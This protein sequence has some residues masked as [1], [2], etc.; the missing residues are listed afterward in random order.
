MRL[1]L[2][3]NLNKVF[4]IL[5][6]ILGTSSAL[7]AT[8]NRAGEITVEQIGPLTVRMTITTYT[9]ASSIE[10]DRDSLIVDW[11]DGKTEF[12]G[13]VNGNGN[14]VSI[15]N[16]TK[17]NQYIAEH[18]YPGR[19]TYTIGMADPNR[20]GGILNVNFPNSVTIQ[21]YLEIQY[22]FLNQQFQ[23]PNNTP[24][25]L[26]PPIDRGCVGQLFTHNPNAY[27]VDGDS[28]AYELIIPQ[29]GPDQVVPNY[30]YPNQ[31]SPG[32]NNNITF[33][34]LTGDFRWENPQRAGE[35]NIAMRINEYRNGQMI[36]STIR[37]LQIEIADCDNRP[38]TVEA[39]EE[40]CVIAGE[41]LNIPL[42]I[43]DPDF[44]D[45]VQITP[46][47]GPFVQD[48]SQAVL[49]GPSEFNDVP[50]DANIQWNTICDHVAPQP[51]TA[52]IRAVDSL[53]NG[54]LTTLKT[55]NIEV[56][57]PAPRDLEAIS[58]T[59][60]ITVS[61][62]SPYACEETNTDYFRGFDVW[63]KINSNPFEPEECETG[64]EGR[65]YTQIAFSVNEM[66][67]GRYTFV[68][69]DVEKGKTYCYR[70]TGV[71]A[72]LSP[73]G[74]PFNFV[75]SIPSEE[76]CQ[77]LK[78]DVPF[79]LN[80]DI[81]NTD[82]SQGEIFVRWIRPNPIDL[83]TIVNPGPYSYQLERSIELNTNNF[84]PIADAFFTYE[85]FSDPID[86]TYLD[87]G[88]NTVDNAYT[89]R[90]AFYTRGN[91]STPYEYSPIATSIRLNVQATDR[92]VNLNWE[93]FVPWENY[94]YA[95]FKFNE[96]SSTFD[97]IAV[98]EDNFY[99]D[100]EVKNEKEYCYV[101]KGYGQYGISELPFPLINFS[102]EICAVP[103]DTVPPCPPIITI[104]NPCTE[105][106]EL[107]TEFTNIIT[108]RIG[109][110]D[111]FNDDLVKY[112]VYFSTS[113]EGPFTL[114]AELESNQN[115]FDHTPPLGSRA[116]YAVTAID[117][118]GNESS[119]LN[120][121]CAEE[122]P[123]YILPNTFTPN[124]DGSNDLFKPRVNRSIES[125]DFK[126]YNRWGNLVFETNDPELNWDGRNLR[127]DV[128]DAAT[129]FY[130]CIY[131]RIGSNG[132]GII[133]SGYI[134]LVK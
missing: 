98:T 69:E 32:G 11:G 118:I 120:S 36:S 91:T 83:D 6:L 70:I 93:E 30:L 97:S 23:G 10:A 109:T 108:W 119:V 60:N 17:L 112:R 38:P 29:Q 19:N 22:T 15:G 56:V 87:E 16:D 13:R 55:I 102:Q 57:A 96:V 25:L 92:R 39:V 75:Q 104:D 41:Q 133:I 123:D 116:C 67:N 101:I 126:V 125:V 122:C 78:R 79:P 1:S 8:H 50:F 47:G 85:N 115:R 5:F 14:G 80:V 4:V 61:W 94:E 31:I 51:Y 74:F 52:I 130:K 49:I 18:T 21:F 103:I 7:L 27:D 71:F 53:K 64:L 124:N 2:D 72:R 62:E 33:N 114:L 77:Q 107:E 131:Y 81:R 28:I 12:V 65:G 63:R 26:Q 105:T 48:F 45:Q 3:Y 73:A 110:G 117:S 134:E 34:E 42:V 132:E 35:Y 127:G 82:L 59:D 43:D 121:S 89:Y 37:D 106:P 54:G 129:Y 76:V 90:I 113:T 24:I 9:Q 84:E 66:E 88:L 44:Q 128:M 46:F 100:L 111:C 20:N 86:S 58:Q 99:T 95:I 40:Y 68:D